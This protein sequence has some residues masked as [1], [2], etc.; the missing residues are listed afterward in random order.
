MANMLAM[1]PIPAAIERDLNEPYA[2]NAQQ[3]ER[4]REDGYIRL[5]E[6]L[7][8]AVL[9]F[10]EPTITRLTLAAA[11]WAAKP[12]AQRNTYE[13]AFLQVGN[14]WEQDELARAFSFAPRLARLATELLG[15]RGVRMYHDQALYKEAGGGF[16]PWHVDQQYWPMETGLSV[17]AWIPLQAVPLEMGPLCFGRGSH[18]KNIGRDLAISDESEQLIRQQ[19]KAQGVLE[20]QEPYALG[21][22]SFHYGFTLHRA[23]PNTLPTPRRVHTVIY[24]DRDMRLAQPKGEP[25]HNDWEKWCHRLPVGSI[26]NGP[27]NPVMFDLDAQA[28]TV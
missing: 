13:K 9:D 4:F 15:T 7:S 26:I 27:R 18:V 12:M 3:I 21:D 22:V 28:A 25:Q 2:L 24:M 11:A 16:T 10:F 14:L 5:P 1:T 17:T 23:G 20:V 6:V 8:A 19:V